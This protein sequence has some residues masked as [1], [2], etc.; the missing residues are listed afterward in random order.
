MIVIDKSDYEKILAHAIQQLPEE[1]C[2]LI[3]GEKNG[4]D[5][6]IRKVYLLTNT[7][8]SGEHFSVDTREQLAVVKDMRM[9]GWVPLGTEFL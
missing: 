6:R 8:H 7:D 4:D 1:A 3:A 9:N 5:K 2:G